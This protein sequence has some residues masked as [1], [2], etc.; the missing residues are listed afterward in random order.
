MRS[1]S[2]NFSIIPNYTLWR[3]LYDAEKF[4]YKGHLNISQ[5]NFPKWKD[6]YLICLIH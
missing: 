4:K 6:Q 3:E 5:Y 2:L 1:G